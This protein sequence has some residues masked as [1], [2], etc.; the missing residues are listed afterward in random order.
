MDYRNLLVKYMVHL[1]VSEGEEF[2]TDF[3]LMS[4]ANMGDMSWTKEETKILSEDIIPEVIRINKRMHNE[5]LD[6]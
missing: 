4:P 5:P 3:K 1:S 6:D 2:A